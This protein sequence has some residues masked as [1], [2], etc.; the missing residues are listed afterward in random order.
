MYRRSRLWTTT[1]LLGALVLGVTACSGGSTASEAADEPSGPQGVLRLSNYIETSSFDPALTV[2]QAGVPIFAEYD[3]LT[4]YDSE[5]KLAPWLAT[6]W[7]QPDAN[8]WRFKLRDDVDFHDGSHFDATTVKLNLERAKALKASPYAYIYSLI[9]SVTVVD[10]YTAEVRLTSP[11]PSFAE[12]MAQVSG[13]MVSP[14]AIQENA[15]LTRAPAGSGGWIW[16]KASHVESSKHVLRANPDYWNPDVVRAETIEVQ[17]L[18]DANA[19][20]NGVESGQLDIAARMPAR[21]W[22]AA[23]AAGLKLHG[24]YIETSVLLILDRGGKLVPAFAEPKVREAVGLLLDRNA[25]AKVIHAGHSD[26]SVGGFS[27]PDSPFYSKA[28][29]ADNPAEA[30]VARAKKL[31]AEAGYPQGFT[32]KQGTTTATRQQDETIAQMLSAGGITV[33]LVDIVGGQFGQEYRKGTYPAGF[34]SPTSTNPWEWWSRG[35]SNNGPYNPFKLTDL[36]DLEAKYNEARS[37]TDLE[38]QKDIMAELQAE[39]IDRG[40]MFPLAPSQLKSGIG[41]SVQGTDKLI[42]GPRDMAP[43][44]FNLWVTP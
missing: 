13:A 9:E 18:P 40:V 3:T 4:S 30:D 20:L 26:A 25:F 28:L 14:K 23:E 21:Q 44:P 32:Y 37:S 24:D 19:R 41:A 17:I 7:E 36:A 10:E 2:V 27:A 38:V 39:I 42:Q 11:W 16:D 31:L 29:D 22:D 43:R 8:T 34:F 12:D 5:G 35:V 1:A 33:E 6:S 15:D